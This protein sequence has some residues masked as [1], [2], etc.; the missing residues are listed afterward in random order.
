MRIDDGLGRVVGARRV[1]AEEHEGSC[2]YVFM[3]FWKGLRYR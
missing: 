2:G 1:D 3:W